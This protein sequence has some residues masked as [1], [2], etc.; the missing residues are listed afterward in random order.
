[1]GYCR[2]CGEDCDTIFSLKGNDY[3]GRCIM[4][5]GFFDKRGLLHAH[6][7]ERNAENA[8]MFTIMLN[9]FEPDPNIRKK[10]LDYLHKCSTDLEQTKYKLSLD[11]VNALCLAKERGIIRP[12]EL[13]IAMDKTNLAMWA[14]PDNFYTWSKSIGFGFLAALVFPLYALMLI[15]TSFKHYDT[16]PRGEGED[17]VYIKEVA[18]NGKNQAWLRL[19]THPNIFLDIICTYLIA[20]NFGHNKGFFNEYFVDGHPLRSFPFTMYSFK[21]KD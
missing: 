7:G 17:R 18:T 11:N 2:E 21:R 13:M 12:N 3:C 1:M 5:D 10:V 8:I 4:E 16:K 6:L 14:R 20:R 9:E 19:R 15:Y